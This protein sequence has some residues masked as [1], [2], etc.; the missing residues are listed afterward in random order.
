VRADEPSDATGTAGSSPRPRGLPWT[1][2]LLSAA[3]VL[4]FLLALAALEGLARLKPLFPPGWMAGN[5]YSEVYGWS[6]RPS[7]RLEWSLKKGDRRFWEHKQA[8]VNEAGYRG[9]VAAAWPAPGRARVVMLG[10][11]ITF[12]HGVGDDETFSAVLSRD[13]DVEAV[14]LGVPGYGTDQELIRLEREGFPLHPQ[15]AVLN[16]CVTNDFY[17]NVLP[18]AF[19]DGRAPK[20][21]FVVEGAGLRLVDAHLKLSWRKRLAVRIAERSYLFNDY[22]ALSGQDQTSFAVG[23]DAPPPEHWSLRARRIH[24]NMGPALDITARLVMEMARA[25]RQHGVRFLVL[26]HPNADSFAGAPDPG[27]ALQADPRLHALDIVDLRARYR[28]RGLAFEELAIDKPGHLTQFG[29]VVVAEVVRAWLLGGSP[30]TS[31]PR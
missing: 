20:P 31:W 22:L 10:D 25:C 29:H 9:P 12:G 30:A 15:A 18:V 2:L 11:S 13:P 23:A 1:N 17:D 28:E 21:Y 8:T 26:L 24:K 5:V 19:F 6:L 27:D 14:N 16:V 7:S 4:A 3:S